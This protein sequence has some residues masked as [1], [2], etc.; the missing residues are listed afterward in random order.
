MEVKD[1]PDVL[2]GRDTLPFLGLGCGFIH[3]I[4][5]RLC[6]RPGVWEQTDKAGVGEASP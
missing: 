1:K 2:G 3:P 5:I 6:V 4:L